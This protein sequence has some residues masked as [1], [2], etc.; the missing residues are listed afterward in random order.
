MPRTAISWT[1]K[2]T[3]PRHTDATHNLILWVSNLPTFQTLNLHSQALN[4]W[5]PTQT[6]I[7]R[8]LY[9]RYQ[10]DTNTRR[11]QFSCFIDE[12][13]LDAYWQVVC[14][15]FSYLFTILWQSTKIILGWLK[16]RNF[17]DMKGGWKIVLKNL[18]QW[19]WMLKWH[20]LSKEKGPLRNTGISEA[21]T[22]NSGIGPESNGINYQI[23]NRKT[24]PP[25]LVTQLTPSMPQV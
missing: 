10:N 19:D 21:A 3:Q 17:K 22:S 16:M 11:P 2:T 6:A 7:H 14:I 18:G 9:R 13:G 15:K 20:P 5:V 8:Q 1:T 4:W 12:M 23:C 25:A 24:T